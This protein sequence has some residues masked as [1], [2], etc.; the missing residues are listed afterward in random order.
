MANCTI[1][2]D[3]MS[4]PLKTCRVFCSNCQRTVTLEEQIHELTAI[5]R[6]YTEGANAMQNK[7]VH[8]AINLLETAIDNFFKIAVLPHR[9]THI[10]QEALISC[11][12]VL[13]MGFL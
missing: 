5:E 1:V 9:S 6:Q 8:L 2:F 7:Q 3:A 13:P 10:A 12:S 11:Y 4:Y